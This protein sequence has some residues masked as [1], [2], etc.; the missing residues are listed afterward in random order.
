MI[1]LLNYKKEYNSKIV[2]DFSEFNAYIGEITVLYGESGCGKTTLLNAINNAEKSYL[3][4][5][6]E[7]NKDNVIRYVSYAPQVPLFVDDLTIK[8]NILLYLTLNNKELDNNKLQ[9][10]CSKL[11]LESMMNQYPKSLSGG[12]LRRVSLLITVLLDKPIILLDEPT[13]SLDEKYRNVIMEI[14]LALKE[15]DRIIIVSTHDEDMKLLGDR[16]YELK[17][18]TLYLKKELNNDI[19]NIREIEYKKQSYKDI[20]ILLRNRMKHH[21]VKSSLITLMTIIIVLCLSFSTI[22][23]NETINGLKNWLD[24]S[25]SNEMLV[26]K[27]ICEGTDDYK[28]FMTPLL[29]DEE[30][31]YLTNHEYINNV[32]PYHSGEV[33]DQQYNKITI[34]ND[35]DKKEIELDINVSTINFASYYEDVDYTQF[36]V[37]E[38]ND[39][40]VYISEEFADYL[41]I[42][43][44]NARIGFYLAI[45][46]RISS[47]GGYMTFSENTDKYYHVDYLECEYEYVEMDIAGIYKNNYMGVFIPGVSNGNSRIYL[48]QN[49]YQSYI[50]KYALEESYVEECVNKIVCK[51]ADVYPYEST[52]YLVS[53]EASHVED[54][55]NDLYERDFRFV[56]EYYD[57]QS[58][59]DAQQ[60]NSNMITIFS[61]IVYIVGCIII[62]SIK[63]TQRNDTKQI[64]RVMS[65]QGLSRKEYYKVMILSWMEDVIFVSIIASILAYGLSMILNTMVFEYT[66][67]N[68]MSI[69]VFVFASFVVC[70]VVPC[71]SDILTLRYEK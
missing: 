1:K 13:A 66:T 51:Y 25:V 36:L 20:Y 18:Q 29:S 56:N 70:F 5:N 41:E 48:E 27:K 39:E 3:I 21:R 6:I 35:N 24:S 62:L 23:G 12:E 61:V 10:L 50:D 52:T 55:L 28:A 31:K 47:P 11:D 60:K 58:L 37:K 19:Q 34:I 54:L 67:F 46:N 22:Y 2:L 71:L 9:E 17:N 38:Y 59:L 44:D 16:T 8:D 26:F 65:L 57:T 49:I 7:V 32:R 15:E 4:G 45:P 42:S 14:L 64:Y 69:F 30:Y 33:N 43:D 63:Y 40:G 68:V 53:Y